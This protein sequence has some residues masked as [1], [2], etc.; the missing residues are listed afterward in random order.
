MSDSTHQHAESDRLPPETVAGLLDTAMRA[1]QSGNIAGARSL[2]R[3]LSAQAPNVPRVWLSLALVAETRAEQRRA[4]EHV[5]ALDP[6]N[7]LARRGL[8]QMGA[9]AQAAP[10]ATPAPPAATPAKDYTTRPLPAIEERPPAAPRPRPRPSLTPSAPSE[11][12][13]ARSIRWPLYLVLALSVVAVLVAAL[14][15]R[16]SWLFGAGAPAAA[17]PALPAAVSG[18]LTPAFVASAVALPIPAGGTGATAAAPPLPAG[19]S[20][21]EAATPIAQPS[22]APPLPTAEPPTAAPPSPTA[23]PEPTP[24]P[25]LA[26]GTVVKQGQWSAVLLRPDYAVPLDGS[27]GALQPRGR[28][29]LA[30]VAVANDGA[31]PARLPADLFAVVDRDG[32]RYLPLPAVSTAYL[33]AYGRGQRGD[34]SMEDAIPADGGNKSVPLIFDVPASARGLTL[35]VKGET[36]G[37]AIGQ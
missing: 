25:G 6:K 8:S 24:P 14:V 34:L 22:A 37:W 17:T 23:V 12:E 31:A 28:F 18:A 7:S 4:L 5:L 36:K 35:L 21:G 19:A 33:D 11:E 3:A 30:L 2:L 26:P 13:R 32:N 9:A 29:L 16:P 20:A 1:R 27:I 15:I 10:P